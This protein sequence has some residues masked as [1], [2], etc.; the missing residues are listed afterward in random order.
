MEM[1]KRYNS[2]G[3]YA[4]FCYLTNPILRRACFDV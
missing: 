3:M 4:F 2:I 1:E